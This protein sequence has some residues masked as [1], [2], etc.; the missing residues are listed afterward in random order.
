M[1]FFGE[2]LGKTN[3]LERQFLLVMLRYATNS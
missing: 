2:N 1:A 3:V